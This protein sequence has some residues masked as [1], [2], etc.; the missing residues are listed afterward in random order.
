MA[1]ELPTTPAWLPAAPTTEPPPPV[2]AAAAPST[3]EILAATIA[4]AVERQLTQY[5]STMS[6]QVETTRQAAEAARL[7]MQAEFAGQLESLTTRIDANQQANDRYQSALQ[8]ALE[9]RLA[10]F[11]NHQHQTLTTINTKLASLPS[12]VQAELPTQFAVVSRG[13]RDYLEHKTTAIETQIDELHKSSRRFDE[14]A[15]SIVAHI[16][17]TV[18]AL[19]RRMDDGDQAVSRTIEQRLGDL[20]GVVDQTGAD[21]ARQLAEHGQILSQRVDAIDMKMVD[22]AMAMEDRINEH[23]GVK[24]ANLEA[25]IGRV[26]AGFDD[27]MGALSK[28]IVDLEAMLLEA[29]DRMDRLAE[30]VSKVDEEAINA[31]KEQLSSAVGEAMLVRIEVDRF[32]AT[33]DEKFD[34]TALRMSEIEAQLADTMDVSEAV[35]LERLEEIERALIELNPSQF[36]R[37]VEASSETNAYSAPSNNPTL[38]ASNTNKTSEPSF[39]SY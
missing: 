18:A 25:T 34:S 5:M 27:A 22:R 4:G 3:T 9:E 16:N 11:A 26:G 7:E 1:N 28:R 24:I 14:Q 15:A 17:E 37:K 23:N 29:G 39:S 33:Q 19:Y 31:V 20:R 8:A 13:L 32:I 6:Q 36:V 21:V 35:Q 2:H 12:L 38:P 30:D 10:E